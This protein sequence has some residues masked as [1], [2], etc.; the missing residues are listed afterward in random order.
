MPSS[1]RPIL[2]RLA[3]VLAFAALISGCEVDKFGAP[4]DSFFSNGCK[5]GMTCMSDGK[6]KFCSQTCT[7]NKAFPEMSDK[8][9]AGSECVEAVYS[10]GSTSAAMGSMC[11]RPK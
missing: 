11:S 9:P 7:V 4:C 2:S 10:K 3:F 5:G 6:G 1:I 8:C